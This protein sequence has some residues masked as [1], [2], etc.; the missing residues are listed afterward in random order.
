MKKTAVI[1]AGGQGERF[2]P[3]SRRNMPKQFLSFVDSGKSMIQLTVDRLLPIVD[4]TD[5][6]V[7]TNLNYFNLLK[8]QLPEIP[9]ENILLEPV[10]KNTA[11]AIGF[12]AAVIK[13]KYDDAVMMILA[14]DHLIKNEGLFLDTLLLASKVAED[15]ENLLT[16]GITPTYPE[17]GY[18]Y[19]N[20]GNSDDDHKGVYEVKRFVEKPDLDK[21]KEYLNDG[22]YLWNSGMFVWRVSTILNQF[23]ALMPN[24]YAGLVDIQKAFGTPNYQE[25]LLESF[26]A[27]EK[28]S[29]DYAIMEQA[30]NIYT[31]PGNFGWDD[32]GNWLAISRIN[33]T[34][35]SGNYVQGQ[36]ITIDT[37]NSTIIGDK[38]MIATVGIKD[39][40]VVDTGDTILICNKNNTQE[41]KKVIE[42]LKISNHDELL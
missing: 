42:H 13:S 19:I 25:V 8:E 24:T 10:A 14:S 26:N 39:I 17:T 38:R 21:A 9:E 29:I 1:M 31:I 4:I 32:V 23:E 20:F 35:D 6:F 30:E 3:K 40:I 22:A 5:I 12:A 11:A 34:N 2:W 41:I 37:N 36:A 33:K 16:I 27:F 15:G 7:V 28:K 18:G